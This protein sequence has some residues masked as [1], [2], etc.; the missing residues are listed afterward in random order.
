M[1]KATK[2]LMHILSLRDP[3]TPLHCLSRNGGI[4]RRARILE[5]KLAKHESSYYHEVTKG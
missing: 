5:I 3:L 2:W 1:S 4:A